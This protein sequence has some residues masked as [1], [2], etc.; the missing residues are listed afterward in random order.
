MPLG[1]LVARFGLRVLVPAEQRARS[2]EVGWLHRWEGPSGSRLDSPCAGDLVVVAAAAVGT[3][4]EAAELVTAAVDAVAA[5]I[6]VDA[7]SPHD[8]LA[9]VTAAAAAAGMPVLALPPGTEPRELAMAIAEQRVRIDAA[10][11]RR[12]AGGLVDLTDALAMNGVPGVVVTLAAHIDGWATLVDKYGQVVTTVGAG[13]VHVDDA[14]S[15]ATAGTRRRRHPGLQV[16]PVGRSDSPKARL[17]VAARPQLDDE[18]REL[19]LHAAR[20]IDLGFFPPVGSHVWPLARRDAVDVLLTDHPIAERVASRWALRGDSFVVSVLRSRSRAVLLEEAALSWI[21]DLGLPPLVAADGSDVQVIVS[22]DAVGDWESAVVAA[23]D[24]GVPVRCGIG[25]ERRLPDLR[26]SH[27][28][29][30]QALEIAIA[31][32]RSVVRFSDLETMRVLL[33]GLGADAVSAL[34]EPLRALADAGPGSDSYLTSLRVF[35]AENGNWGAASAQLR[36]HRHTLRHRIERVQELTGLDM[37]SA[38]DRFRAW[39]AL[40]ALDAAVED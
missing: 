12:V 17:V 36:I 3:A 23:S 35:L 11:A 25:G 40:R 27:R 31:D 26:L 1:T 34:A 15:A 39:V 22:A 33:S 18:A 9:L 30:R 14:V 28:Q 16:V 4:D 38:E 6:C 7:T 32:S 5:A 20:L 2:P 10:K 29:A 8:C 21:T 37:T 24:D 19:A 13:R